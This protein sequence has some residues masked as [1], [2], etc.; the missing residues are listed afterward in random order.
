MGDRSLPDERRENGK[1]LAS[2][3]GRAGYGVSRVGVADDLSAGLTPVRFAGGAL[4][5]PME[6][7]RA[8]HRGLT[9]TVFSLKDCPGLS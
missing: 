8:V 7:R 9:V 1:E 5:V 2:L 3:T 6:F 4:V